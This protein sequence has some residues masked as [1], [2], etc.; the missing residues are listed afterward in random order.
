MTDAASATSGTTVLV[1]G[2]LPGQTVRC[3]I[4]ARR[5]RFLEAALLEVLR[6][7][8]DAIPPLC[9]HAGGDAA[10]QTPACGGCALQPMPY[11]RQLEWKARLARDALLRIGGLKAE[12]LGGGGAGR[13]PRP[14]L[15]ASATA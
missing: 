6:P 9:P 4:I 7:A 10:P 14:A 11:A 1:E 15:P 8:P 13:P 3:R 2:A 5:P 12:N